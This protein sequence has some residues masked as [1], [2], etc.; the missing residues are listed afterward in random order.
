L[1]EIEKL[2]FERYWQTFQTNFSYDNFWYLWLKISRSGGGS[3]TKKD[4][5]NSYI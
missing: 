3:L 5:L 1:K 4:A 2:C